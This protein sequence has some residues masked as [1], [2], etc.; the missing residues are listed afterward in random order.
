[1]RV[2]LVVAALFALL[3]L[4]PQGEERVEVRGRFFPDGSPQE[5]AEALVVPG[6]D[7]VYHGKF[8]AFAADG[9]LAVEGRYQHGVK[10][11]H[12]RY[13]SPSGALLGEGEYSDGCCEFTQYHPDGSVQARGPK[14]GDMRTGLWTE[15]YPDGRL[16][17]RGE[18]VDEAM[19]G[20]WVYWTDEDP[21]REIRRVFA[22]GQQVP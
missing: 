20:T 11:G 21:P 1:M 10:V 16:R 19:H 17:M 12:W 2:L 14:I 15:W 8:K 3:P 7:P 13:F 5:L 4:L 6:Q 9:S 18:F 22:H